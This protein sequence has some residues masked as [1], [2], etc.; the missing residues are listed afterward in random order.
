MIILLNLFTKHIISCTYMFTFSPSCV[1]NSPQWRAYIFNEMRQKGPKV[2][3]TETN[4]NY[5]QKVDR[6]GYIVNM[7]EY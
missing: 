1:W 4:F 3:Y 2:F 7:T 6:T 5:L